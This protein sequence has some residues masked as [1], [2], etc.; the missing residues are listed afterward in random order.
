MRPAS[1][2]TKHACP[3]N[4]HVSEGVSLVVVALLAGLFSALSNSSL[5]VGSLSKYAIRAVFSAD[6]SRV[7]A[8]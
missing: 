6:G 8:W 5:A 4:G 2:P 3:W 7:D 1:P